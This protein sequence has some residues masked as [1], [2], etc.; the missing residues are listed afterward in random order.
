M[1]AV[2]FAALGRKEE[3]VAL[4]QRGVARLPVDDDAFIGPEWRILM[5]TTYTIV[6]EHERAITELEYVLSIPAFISPALLQ[7]D[8]V[9]DPLR[10]YARFQALLG[11]F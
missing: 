10:G 3:A 9:W 11:E 8:P 7:V 2:A 5:A 6:G 4:A 1:L